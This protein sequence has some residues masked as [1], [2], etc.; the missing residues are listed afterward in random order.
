MISIFV[1]ACMIGLF[2]VAGIAQSSADNARSIALHIIAHV[3][4]MLEQ[5]G[6]RVIRKHVSFGRSPFVKFG[7]ASANGLWIDLLVDSHRGYFHLQSDDPEGRGEADQPHRFEASGPW[8]ELSSVR[9]AGWENTFRQW[10]TSGCRFM[11]VN[12]EPEDYIAYYDPSLCTY[13]RLG[14]DR[15]RSSTDLGHKLSLW[16][17]QAKPHE[18]Y[19]LVP[20]LPRA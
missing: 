5:R 19:P 16:L 12:N 15:A 8:D 2:V 6:Y 17:E 20:V 9:L 18:R 1:V 10:R 3:V 14:H 7:L 11:S 13:T 4:P